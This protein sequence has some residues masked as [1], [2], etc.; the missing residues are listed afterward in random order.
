MTRGMVISLIK[1]GESGKRMDCK[2]EEGKGF[3]LCKHSLI[4]FQNYQGHYD[5][6]P[7][8]CFI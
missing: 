7:F 4:A 1:I 2:W 6:V 8:L 3:Y 5:Y